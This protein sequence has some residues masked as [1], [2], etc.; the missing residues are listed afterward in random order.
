LT[1]ERPASATAA[2]T[3]IKSDLIAKRDWLEGSIIVQALT[4]IA[5]VGFVGDVIALCLP[6]L[7][8]ACW[9]GAA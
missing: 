8:H 3:N 6:N 5:C 1:V 4:T 7:R 2:L 9:S